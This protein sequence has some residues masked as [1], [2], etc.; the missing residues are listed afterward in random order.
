MA[1][2]CWPAPVS[3][4]IRGLPIRC[5]EQR[6]A[7]RV[8]D[9]VGAGVGEVL[10]L[11]VDAAADPLGEAL[12]QVERRRPADE[13]APQQR[14][15]AAL[16]AGVVARLLPGR[17]QLV[18][19]RDQRLRHVAAP[20]G[21]EALLDRAHASG[22][23]SAA[24][25]PRRRRP[26][27]RGPCGRARPRR[28]WRRRPRRAGRPR[29]PR[30][31]SRAAG[32]RRGSP[33][34]RSGAAQQLPVEA[35]AGA[36]PEALAAPVEE[37]EVGAVG[38]GPVDVGGAGDVDRLDHLDPGPARHLGAEAAPSSPFSCT[39]VSPRP[40]PPWRPRPGRVD[41]D[42]DDLALAPESRADRRRGPPARR[43]A[44]C[45]S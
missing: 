43:A 31:R 13:V 41:E 11:Q 6:L 27:R 3:A 10:A 18:E 36:A 12:G 33:G 5:G 42:A 4:M 26:S 19:R 23:A 45:C 37:V 16:K 15:A 21:A 8:V 14:R 2:P 29:S 24:W 17:G 44:G 35:L 32:R 34:P 22:D 39:I 9:L 38:L 1:T 20:V 7:E 30:R 25:P 40:R 28:R